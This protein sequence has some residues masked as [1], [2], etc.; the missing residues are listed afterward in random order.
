LRIPIGVIKEGDRNPEHWIALTGGAGRQFCRSVSLDSQNGNYHVGYL[1]DDTGLIIKY[2]NQ[3]VSQFKK[4]LKT[5]GINQEFIN[6]GKID[7][8]GSLGIVGNSNDGSQ[9]IGYVAKYTSSGSYQ[10]NRSFSTLFINS[11][12]S[13]SANNFYFC[14][15]VF[16]NR[17]YLGKVNSSGAVQWQRGFGINPDLDTNIGLSGI[18][19]DN[20]GN[21]VA[22]GVRN[23]VNAPTQATG[24][25]VKYDSSGSLIWQKRVLDTSGIG[26]IKTAIDSSNNIYVLG[27]RTRTDVP[28]AFLQHPVLI[29]FNSSGAIQWQRSISKEFYTNP[30]DLAIGA[31]S[32][33]YVSQDWS[34]PGLS[35]GS[36]VSKINS[37]GEIIWQR[38]I[39]EPGRTGPTSPFLSISGG[40]LYVSLDRGSSITLNPDSEKL[41]ISMPT[42]TN[43]YGSY[44]IAST[45]IVIEPIQ[46]EFVASSFSEATPSYTSGAES[47]SNFTPSGQ[48]ITDLSFPDFKTNF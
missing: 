47:I 27:Y 29:K 20:A 4:R 7:A 30:A 31:D 42:G 38:R 18:S 37:S 46:T 21:V 11:V 1:D 36:V 41:S 13:D 40:N 22:C 10:W 8:S 35:G 9:F 17:G 32:S 33:L 25:L 28:S 45:R 43:N 23:V 6:L 14:G 19:L 39:N 44:N 5:S 26:F 3:G 2:N 34:Q 15:S 16:F 48:T 12:D 24:I